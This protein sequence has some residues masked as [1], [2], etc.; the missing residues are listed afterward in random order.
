MCRNDIRPPDVT[1]LTHAFTQA[2]HKETR[3][4]EKFE[5]RAQTRIHTTLLH[6]HD[7]AHISK[8]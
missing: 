6:W 5:Q 2:K 8:L 3:A 1:Q 4:V 7:F